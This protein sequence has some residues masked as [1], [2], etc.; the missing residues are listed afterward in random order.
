MLIRNRQLAVKLEAVEGT[1]VV[2]AAAD[3]KF[4]IYESRLRL[5]AEMQERNP[6][7]G[8]LSQEGKAAGFQTAVLTGRVE[9]KGSGTATT[10]PAWALLLRGAGWQSRLLRRFTIG[11]ITGGPMQH[12]E[13]VT[14]TGT[15]ATGAVIIKTV[16]GTTTLYVI[17]LTGTFNGTGVL[18]GGVS[19]ATCTPSAINDA[20]RCYNPYSY[21]LSAVNIGAITGGPFTA[22]EVITG[23]TS[24]GKGIVFENTATGAAKVR[25]YPVP[26]TAQIA[27]TE[28]ITGGTSGATATTSA[29]GTQDEVPSLTMS[30]QHDQIRKIIKGCRGKVKFSLAAGKFGFLDF[31]FMGVH[32]SVADSAPYAGISHETTKPPMFLNAAFS[33]GG[34]AA[35]ISELTIDMQTVVAP[36]VSANDPGGIISYRITAR[37]PQ[38]SFDP[39]AV[40]KSAHDVFGM[41]YGNTEMAVDFTLGTVAGNTLR[42]YMDKAQYSGLEDADRE[43]IA[44]HPATM[45]LNRAQSAGDDEIVILHL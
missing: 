39:E 18:T 6:L 21:E 19:G 5:S 11:A 42:F 17:P 44:T 9:L 14:Q 32:S 8:T 30:S 15:G 34:F 29:A 38:L 27:T 23:G 26:G 43:G 25:Y 45:S 20:G 2:P 3:G 12:M 33:V 13:T 24:G 35:F 4:L 1:A 10:D 36:R 37:D 16:T 22:G 31:E 7:R 41:L 28:T 40:L